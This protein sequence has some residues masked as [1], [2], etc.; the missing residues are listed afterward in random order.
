[1]ALKG[2]IANQTIII[3]DHKRGGQ[4]I[5][6]WDNEDNDVHID[7]T[8]NHR[9]EGKRQKVR[10]KI[11]INSQR[12]IQ[13]ENERKDVVQEIPRK[14]R[15]EIIKALEDEKIRTEFIQ[16]VLEVLE[17]FATVLSNEERAKQVLENLSRHFELK[18]TGEKIVSYVNNILTSY[19]EVFTD[20]KEDEYF[21]KLTKQ[22]IEI[23][24]NN[25]Y[26]KWSKKINR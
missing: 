5:K 25:G 13:I 18:W 24:Q 14:L 7:K 9:I 23:G 21:A 22:R 11:P 4:E 12:Q 2:L 19:T 6:I 10:I 20:D 15:R 8:T 17:N 26:A 16:D 1:M 3:D